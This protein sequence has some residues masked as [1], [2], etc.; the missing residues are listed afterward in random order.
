VVPPRTWPSRRSTAVGWLVR[1]DYSPVSTHTW[2]PTDL[3]A[4]P[5]MIEIAVRVAGSAAAELVDYTEFHVEP[6][7]DPILAI[8]FRYD[9]DAVMDVLV[10]ERETG[11]WRV[12]WANAPGQFTLARSGGWAAGW[13][14]SVADFNGD[15][16][17]D[18]FL[19]SSRT[20]DWFK[21]INTNAVRVVRSG[22]ADRVQHARRGPERRDFD[23]DGRSDLFIHRPIGG[24][25]Y[26]PISLGDGSFR[27]VGGGWASG[28]TSTIADLNGDGRSDVFLYYVA[29]GVAYRAVST[30]DGTAGFG[31]DSV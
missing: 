19:Y 21:V 23:G 6:S 7:P 14:V 20:G 5:H 12:Q 3:D 9:T 27:Y 16:R 30:G 18:F 4:D 25:Y 17:D 8:P 31:L 11:G 22:M 24:E 26:K 1:Q 2:T 29:N 28:W 15:G 10:Y 13:D